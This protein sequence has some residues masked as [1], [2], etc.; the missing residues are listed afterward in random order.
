MFLHK[1]INFIKKKHLLFEIILIFI[2]TVPA[3]SSI[4]N[5]YYFSMHDSQ[6]IARLFLLDQGIKQGYLYPRWVDMLGFNYGYP[7]FNFYPPLIYYIAEFFHLAGFSLITSVKAVLIL[8]FL[9]SSLG[10]YLLARR[11]MVKIPAFLSAVLYTYFF[12]H[13]VNGFVRGA[14][15]EFFAMAIIPY[16]FLSL[17]ILA[18]KTNL[19]NTIIYGLM[20]GFLIINHPLIAFPFL[21]YLGLCLLFYLITTQN[22]LSFIKYFALGSLIA[23]SLSSFFWLPSIME[24]KYTYV[25][26]I[27]TKEL[28]DYKIHYIYLSQFIYSPWGYGGSIKGPQD[29][30][31]FQLGKIPIFLGTAALVLSIILLVKEKLFRRY[32]R[33]YFLVFLTFFSLFMTTSYSSFIWDNLKYLWYLQFPWRFLTFAGLFLSLV[34]AYSIVFIG[35]IFL[36]LKIFK[37]RKIF[38]LLILA[39]TCCISLFTIYKYQRY[40]RPQ[41]LIA[42]TDKVLT[43]FDEIA[44]RVSRSS[45]EFVPKGVK[46]KKSELNTTILDIDKK[47]LPHELYSVLKG[48][49][50]VKIKINK[51]GHK[52]F[53]IHAQTPLIFRLNTFYFPGWKAYLN[54]KEIKIDDDNDFKLITVSIPKGVDEV[55]FVFQDTLVRKIANYTSVVVFVMILILIAKYFLI[56]RSKQLSH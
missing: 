39:L 50:E 23:L 49:G 26:E 3:F 53:D 34:A 5:G 45:F 29:G 55:R 47:N 40:F 14:L 25:D 32:R 31:T 20:F 16:V 33:F 8:G 22:K 15:A 35:K 43:D 42:A 19:T 13:A 7:L 38:T 4:L 41:R 30:M 28:A 17:D 52:E 37:N 48:E 24:K 6:H 1:L 18:K 46:T 27:L 21:L 56:A 44:W 54:G 51:F 12:Y 9:L 11:F 36:S 10:A 2:I